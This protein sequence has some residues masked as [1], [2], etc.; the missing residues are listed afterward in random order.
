[1]FYIFEHNSKKFLLKHEQ[2]QAITETLAGSEEL[3]TKYMGSGKPYLDLLVTPK[4]ID[5]LRLSVLDQTSYDA[6]V[7][8]SKLHAESNSI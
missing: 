7:L 5:A 8:V 2:V 6:L 4:V 3:T 1:M